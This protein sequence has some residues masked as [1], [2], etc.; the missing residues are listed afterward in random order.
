MLPRR[1][2]EVALQILRHVEGDLDAVLGRLIDRGHPQPVEDTVR[3]LRAL[4]YPHRQ[5][6]RQ[7]R[8]EL[9]QGAVLVCGE[10]LAE[11]G[12]Q[13]RLVLE[14]TLL[15]VPPRWQI[16]VERDR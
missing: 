10:L 5:H 1:V 15:V 8:V 7:T 6:L 2:A 3:G 14:V 12:G 13:R 9:A 16:A 11:Y 4:R